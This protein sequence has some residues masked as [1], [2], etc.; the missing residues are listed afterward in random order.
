M[1][2]QI[3]K[4]NGEDFELVQEFELESDMLVALSAL[5]A[6]VED[7]HAEINKGS[8]SMILGV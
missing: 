6:S 8:S 3:Y 5:K 1:I 7:C 2:Y 4:K